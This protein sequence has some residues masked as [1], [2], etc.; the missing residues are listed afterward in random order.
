MNI[1]SRASFLAGRFLSKNFE[2]FG[3]GRIGVSRHG[4]VHANR[5]LKALA[6]ADRRSVGQGAGTSCKA[7]RQSIGKSD[8][9]LATDRAAGGLPD[10]RDVRQ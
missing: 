8:L 7:N 5:R 4:L 2:P 1:A 3:P 6:A 9:S 10:R